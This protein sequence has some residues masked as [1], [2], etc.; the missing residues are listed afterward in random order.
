MYRRPFLQ[1]APRAAAASPAAASGAR[2]PAGGGKA[3]K[4]GAKSTTRGRGRGGRKVAGSSRVK[5]EEEVEAMEEQIEEFDSEEL[6]KAVT[7]KARAKVPQQAKVPQVSVSLPD[8]R[9]EAISDSSQEGRR[10]TPRGRGA[11]AMVSQEERRGTPRGRGARVVAITPRGRGAREVAS[12]SP[13]EEECT[14][15][16][17]GGM[18]RCGECGATEE[19][20]VCSG[21]RAVAYCGP[22][23]QEAAWR[24][25]HGAE[26]GE[27]G[28]SGEVQGRGRKKR[29]RKVQG[30]M[31][32]Q[33]KRARR[34]VCI[35]SQPQFAPSQ[36][37]ARELEGDV[38]PRRSILKGAPPSAVVDTN[39]APSATS[40]TASPPPDL[41]HL[42]DLPSSSS[43]PSGP[44]TQ[45]SQ[46]PGTQGSQASTISTRTPSNSP[47]LVTSVRRGSEARPSLRRST[48]YPRAG[49]RGGSEGEGEEDEED[50][51]EARL[52]PKKL[53]F[54][55]FEVDENSREVEDKAEVE[56]EKRMREGEWF[57]AGPVFMEGE[58]A[59]EQEGKEEGSTVLEQ[60]GREEGST[61]PSSSVMVSQQ[62]S[63]PCRLLMARVGWLVLSR[64][65][66]VTS[67]DP[68]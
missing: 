49:A 16:W 10:G 39:V 60:E 48:P 8:E 42:Q 57:I 62:V 21:C 13:S 28:S 40:V 25:G 4:R 68:S 34:S 33:A 46:D 18:K 45:G 30:S 5:V 63:S 15:G 24:G 44:S 61:A 56:E 14:Y 64:F 54:S 52:P 53:Y 2:A 19:V 17:S 31:V 27:Q 66:L 58:P 29:V 22:R 47:T 67:C 6:V 37:E 36:Q 20:Q 43:I 50:E 7:P 32:T 12:Q 55:E 38:E 23:C 1:L 3:S 11:R 35:N 26:C 51:K 9:T 41:N 59:L 65:F